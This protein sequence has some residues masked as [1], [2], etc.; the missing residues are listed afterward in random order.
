M[1]TVYIFVLN[2]PARPS[3]LVLVKIENLEILNQEKYYTTE[4]VA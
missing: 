1:P 2:T 4:P 3:E